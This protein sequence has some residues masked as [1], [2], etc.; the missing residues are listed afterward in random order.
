MNL[1]ECNIRDP[2]PFTILKTTGYFYSRE[3]GDTSNGLQ[4][5]QASPVLRATV[6]LRYYVW[7]IRFVR[8]QPLEA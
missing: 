7:L 3:T 8:S 4:P 6:Q 5:R 2:R 1:T